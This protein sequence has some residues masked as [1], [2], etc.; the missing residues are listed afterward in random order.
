M[1]A[2]LVVLLGLVGLAY[3]AWPGRS[4][5]AGPHD[6]EADR[7]PSE[8]EVTAALRRWSEAAGEL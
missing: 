1:T 5:G 7:Q 2:L 8:D 3:A 6:L 4:S